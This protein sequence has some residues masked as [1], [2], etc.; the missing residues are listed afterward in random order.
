MNSIHMMSDIV[1]TKETMNHKKDIALTSVRINDELYYQISNCD[2]MRPFFMSIVSDSNHWLFISSNG[3]LTAG[4]KNAEY[5]LFPYYTDDKITESADITGSKSIFK[6]SKN[7]QEYLWEPLAIRSLGNYRTSQNLYKNKYG[8]KIIFEEINHDLELIFR[9]EWNSSNQ[10][11]FVKKSTLINTSKELL[12]VELLDGIQNIMPASIGSDIQNQSSNLV[13][14]YKRNELEESTGLGIYALSAILVDKAEASE[15][16]KANV[17]WSIGLENPT[18]LVSSLQL[19]NFRSCQPVKQEVDIKAEKGA[20]FVNAEISLS[21]EV[22]KEWMIVANVNQNHSDIAR[23]SKEIQENSSLEKEIYKDIELGTKRL[24]DLNAASDAI[25]CSAD[26]LK[27]TRHFSNTLFNIMRGGI[28]DNN[29]QIEKWDFINYLKNAN[30]KVA[31]TSEGVLAKLPEVFSLS[32]IQDIANS[33]DDKNFRR[34]CLEYMPLKFSRRHGDPSRPWN[35]FSINTRNE[36]DGSKILDY[37]G[38]WRDIFQNWEALAHSYPE[39]IESMIH[40]FLN[41]TTF[42][43]YNPYRVTKSGFDW[44]VIEPDDPWSYIGYWGDHQI[45]Y[46]LKFLEFIQNHQPGKLE[47]FF[48]KDLFVYANVPY[49]IKSYQDLLKNPK[50]TIVFDEELDAKIRRE[51]NELGADGALLRD[52]NRFIVKVNFIEKIL[53]T[54]LAKLSNFIPEG[55]IW[56]NTQRPEWNDANNALVGNGVSMVTLC[57]LHRFFT[58]FDKLLATTHTKEVAVSNEVLTFFD[59]VLKTF[60]EHALLLDSSINDTNRKIILDALGKSGSDY[61]TKIYEHAFSGRK[62]A[63]SLK[64]LKRFISLSNQYLEHSIKANKRA[65]NLYHAYNLMTVN[66][67]NSVSISYLNEMLEGQVAVLSSGYLSSKEALD[68]LNALK[69]SKLFRHD[70][71]SY[72]LYPNKELK[73]FLDRNNIPEDTVLSSKLLQELLKDGNVQIIEKDVNGKYHFNGNFKNADDL[74]EALHELS[75]SKYQSLVDSDTPKVLQAFED[76]FNHKAFTG[77]SGTFYGYEGLGSI[78]WHMVSKLLLAVQECALKAVN[79][80]ESDVLIGHLL[81]HYYEINEG[82]GVHKSPSLYG[83]FPTDPYSHTPAGKGAQQPGMTGQVKE[84]VL[85]RFGELG[86]FVTQGKIH[87]HPCLLRKSEFIKKAKPFHYVSLSK[88]RKTITLEKGSLGFTFCQVPVVY[89]ISEKDALSISFKDGSQ[90]VID[91]LVIGDA[92]SQQVFK[93]TGEVTQIKVFVKED[94]LK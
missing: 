94:L 34:L 14:A 38:N 54:S 75:E 31:R 86:V 80:N 63:L 49:K 85:S 93:R 13:D 9:Y 16:L 53:A 42:D 56:M 2:L 33:S 3:G 50:D 76:V 4:R 82:I 45:I 79:N 30:K 41:A 51:R 74:S 61:R 39:F 35:K 8:N 21:P 64:K 29:Y 15:A 18:Y 12:K 66:G 19:D 59:Q 62:T 26:S 81:E 1:L 28:F 48:S 57:Y 47:G 77:R 52:E 27:D 58:F 40:K 20:Y 72:L 73:G 17:A 68:V 65:D 91:Q 89:E 90:K 43:G 10:F 7:N 23:L 44:E 84:D 83:A 88:E 78:Y 6:V 71:Y 32:S 36:D 70:Q 55:G 92:I 11:G 87:F 25:Q 46:L 60:E 69:K 22:S 5:A 67:D 37:E 24:V